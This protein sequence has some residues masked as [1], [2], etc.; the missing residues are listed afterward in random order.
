VI[1]RIWHGSTPAAKANEYLAFLQRRALPDCRGTAGNRAAYILRRSDG[2]IAHFTTVTHW[3]CLQAIQ[4][5]ADVAR[6]ACVS[7]DVSA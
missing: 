6:S 1:A 5:F 4:A 7:L 2:D 3:D